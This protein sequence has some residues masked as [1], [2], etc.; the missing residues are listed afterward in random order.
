[1]YERRV[2]FNPVLVVINIRIVANVEMPSF[3]RFTVI[4]N[5]ENASQ[6]IVANKS[7]ASV[8]LQSDERK[9]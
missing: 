3:D 4:M 1:M 5:N 9:E 7:S 2:G 6:N 8:N